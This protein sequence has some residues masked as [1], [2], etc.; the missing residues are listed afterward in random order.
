[1]IYPL[2]RSVVLSFHK[3][4]GPRRV[5]FIGLSNYRFLLGDL[6]FWRAVANTLYFTIVYLTM[7]VPAALG[8]TTA[9]IS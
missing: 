1:M 7:Q 8:L 6:I 5:V 9:V 4:A 2:G 3:A